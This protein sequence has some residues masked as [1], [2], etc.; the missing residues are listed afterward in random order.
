MQTNLLTDSKHLEMSS[1]LVSHL[2]V[3]LQTYGKQNNMKTTVYH[4]YRIKQVHQSLCHLWLS[5]ILLLPLFTRLTGLHKNAEILLSM[6]T[7]CTVMLSLVVSNTHR[8][9]VSFLLWSRSHGGL[10]NKRSLAQDFKNK[11]LRLTK[12]K[13]GNCFS[14]INQRKSSHKRETETAQRTPSIDK[15]NNVQNG[16]MQ[17]GQI[18]AITSAYRCKSRKR[19]K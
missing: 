10:N 9:S 1:E 17:T 4:S 7:F 16:Q 2:L 12:R 11:A 5:P 13:R 15:T 6:S 18:D 14:I 8:R 19:K 3:K